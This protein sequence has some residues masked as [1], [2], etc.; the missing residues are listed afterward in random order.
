MIVQGAIEYNNNGVLTRKNVD[1]DT[2]KNNSCEK[3]VCDAISF[4]L[5]GKTVFNDIISS[6]FG[7]PLI[8]LTVENN[9]GV[10]R[11]T[12]QPQYTR[13]THFGTEYLSGELFIL[14]TKDAVYDSISSEKYY[15][16]MKEYADKT[17]EEFASY[18]RE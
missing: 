18:C 2:S 13:I 5:Y 3:D 4:A 10:V 1:I 15:E 16:L 9:G 12:R 6:E 11:V 17:Y 7:V 8:A 14:E